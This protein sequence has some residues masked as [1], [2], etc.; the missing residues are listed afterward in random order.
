MR[1]AR[2]EEGYEI[3]GDCWLWKGKA[4]ANGYCRMMIDGKVERVHRISW[5]LTHGYWPEYLRHTC[6][7]PRCVNVKHLT[8]GRRSLDKRGQA[9]TRRGVRLGSRQEKFMRQLTFRYSGLTDA[10]RGSGLTWQKDKTVVM[11]LE[12]KGFVLVSKHEMVG[13][14]VVRMTAEGKRRLNFVMDSITG[15][16]VTEEWP[17]YFGIRQRQVMRMFRRTPKICLRDMSE[18][19]GLELR[20][21]ERIATVLYHYQFIVNEDL[22]TFV[23]TKRGKGWLDFDCFRRGLPS[24][25]AEITQ[26]I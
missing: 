12:K 10:L 6:G 1:D 3:D 7:E 24:K 22:E 5:Y 18:R 14:R 2:F 13:D 9:V 15:Q 17:P 19:L 26:D 11:C 23:L 16:D 25:Y 21:A 8:N 4:H 20:H